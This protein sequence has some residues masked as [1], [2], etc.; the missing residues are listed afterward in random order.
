MDKIKVATTIEEL[1][2][3]VLRSENLLPDVPE[4]SKYNDAM[5]F[6]CK[7]NGL[8]DEWKILNDLKSEIELDGLKVTKGG[9]SRQRATAVKA[10]SAKVYK[11]FIDKKP[12]CA[13]ITIDKTTGKDA[14]M[15]AFWG[16]VFND[17]APEC[18]TRSPEYNKGQTVSLSNQYDE[19]SITRCFSLSSGSIETI[20][21]TR[22]AVGGKRFNYSECEDRRVT[23][24]TADKSIQLR[25][26]IEYLYN[27]V[28]CIENDDRSFELCYS[29]RNKAIVI[30][31][32]NGVGLVIPKTK[33][34]SEYEND[35]ILK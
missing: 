20:Y 11:K 10:L 17:K 18:A 9:R 28:K 19:S 23:F 1:I 7:W 22:K 6:A 5:T 25:I 15:T 13:G 34:D 32:E 16:V 30:K 21:K 24:G 33:D 12:V 26:D 3:R 35:Y 29:K 14:L 31:T 2:C 27:V 4:K 8:E